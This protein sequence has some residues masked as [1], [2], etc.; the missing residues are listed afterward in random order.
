MSELLRERA[1]VAAVEKINRAKAKACTDV[2]AALNVVDSS[3]WNS[4]KRSI[5]VPHQ[6]SEALGKT[7]PKSAVQALER[8]PDSEIHSQLA[9]LTKQCIASHCRAAELAEVLTRATPA[10]F[11]EQALAELP[12]TNLNAVNARRTVARLQ[13]EAEVLPWWRQWRR[14]TLAAELLHAE[15]HARVMQEKVR[16][17]T[18]AASAPAREQIRLQQD[19]VANQ[20][21]LIAGQIA[22]LEALA[23]DTAYAES[24]RPPPRPDR[25]TNRSI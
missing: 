25:R 9:N 1:L 11:I 17:Q 2:T 12:S 18:K 6:E 21:R 16:E 15:S 24:L 4:R 19:S 10:S 23:H 22:A 7:L 13:E 20:L 8:L 5:V 14:R 3:V